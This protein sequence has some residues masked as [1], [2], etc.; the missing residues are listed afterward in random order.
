MADGV[1]EPYLT[2]VVRSAGHG[3]GTRI[4]SAARLVRCVLR[5][6]RLI[7]QGACWGAAVLGYVVVVGGQARATGFGGGVRLRRGDVAVPVPPSALKSSAACSVTGSTLTQDRACPAGE[8]TAE[9]QC[10]APL[11]VTGGM[12]VDMSLNISLP[13]GWHRSAR[14]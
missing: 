6:G 5:V 2:A 1:R 8:L 7:R 10:H 4:G 11:S 3:W 14:R 12:L 9:H 13:A